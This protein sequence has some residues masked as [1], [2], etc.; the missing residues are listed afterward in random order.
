MKGKVNEERRNVRDFRR[1]EQRAAD[2]VLLR[3]SRPCVS[4][5]LKERT[6][7]S[8]SAGSGRPESH[9]LVSFKF[10]D[11][12][13][14]RCVRMRIQDV[15]GYREKN[16]WVGV[17]TL[18]LTCPAPHLFNVKDL[19]FS[20]GFPADSILPARNCAQT[21]ALRRPDRLL[22]AF[23][24]LLDHLRL[25]VSP[26]RLPS[27]HALHLGLQALYSPRV[28]LVDVC[29]RSGNVLS[30]VNGEN[31]DGDMKTIRDEKTAYR[32]RVPLDVGLLVRLKVS[33]KK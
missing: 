31:K 27:G 1:A 4:S 3:R 19:K 17:Q 5:K 10:D 28:E 25:L 9:E 29:S 32:K 12:C 30:E 26:R 22:Q 15:N 24:H 21:L 13:A 7:C 18:I 8:L 20:C 14:V 16:P 33:R 11:L 6:R 2:L 23:S